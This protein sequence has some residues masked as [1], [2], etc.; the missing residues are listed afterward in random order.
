MKLNI[1]TSKLS[2]AIVAFCLGQVALL[3]QIAAYGHVY[4]FCYVGIY[5]GLWGAMSTAI[6]EWEKAKPNH[7][8]IP[9]YKKIGSLTI[10][11]GSPFIVLPLIV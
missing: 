4:S 2:I 1:L 10:L 7:P 8:D 9:K 5:I 3:F 11:F 6:I